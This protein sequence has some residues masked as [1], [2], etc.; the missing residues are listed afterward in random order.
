VRSSNDVALYRMYM[1]KCAYIFILS[2]NSVLACKS[3][4][5]KS[6][7]PDYCRNE[8]VTC[9][10]QVSNECEYFDDRLIIRAECG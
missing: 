2:Y 8:S 1:L 10:S 6:R 7:E 4:Y 9:K 5:H 3:N